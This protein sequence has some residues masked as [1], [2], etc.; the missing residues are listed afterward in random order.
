MSLFVGALLLGTSL[1]FILLGWAISPTEGDLSEE[2]WEW[3]LESHRT[4]YGSSPERCVDRIV[5]DAI[6]NSI[7][8]SSFVPEWMYE[9]VRTSSQ[10][11]DQEID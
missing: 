9:P 1:T 6:Y 2:D 7:R 11:F 8:N 3:A 10:P 4:Y 5:F